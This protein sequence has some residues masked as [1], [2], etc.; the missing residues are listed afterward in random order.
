MKLSLVTETFPPEVNGVAL[1][2]CR[3]ARSLSRNEHQVELVRPKPA[4]HAPAGDGWQAHEVHVPGWPMPFYPGL[5]LGQFCPRRLVQHW[6]VHAPDAVHIATEG[7]LGLAALLAAGHLGI[8]VT[9]TFHTNFQSYCRHYYLPFLRARALRYMRWF[10]N[11]CALTFVPT[12]ELLGELERLGFERLQ[13]LGRG[14]D[15]RLFH[16]S[17]RSAELRRQWGAGNGA[18]VILCVSRVAREKNLPLVLEAFVEV[19]R[20]VPDARM[21]IVGDGPVLPKLRRRFPQAHYAGMRLGE[22]LAIHYASADLFFFASTTETFGNVVLEAM[23]SGLVVLTYDYAAGR[24]YV[25]HL[26]SGVLVP[27]DQPGLFK[28]EARRLLELKDRWSAMAEAARRA[29]SAAPWAGV[30]QRFEAALRLQAG[31]AQS[32]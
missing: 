5:R 18:P 4:A 20:A 22:E 8:P 1:T 32:A 2:N 21:V 10:H 25:R 11:Q 29:T 27:Y 17:R 6:R 24:Q 13:H 16:P 23:A 7:P 14:V 26:Q 9:S 19:K 28:Q 12:T 3:L 15:R 30:V 31:V